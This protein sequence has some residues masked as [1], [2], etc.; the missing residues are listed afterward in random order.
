MANWELVFYETSS[1]RIPVREFIDS[2][3]EYEA[4]RVSQALGVLAELGVELTMPRVRRLGGSPIWELRV[5]GRNQHRV[6]YVAVA[7]Q[8]MLLLH[9]FQKKSQATPRR[10]IETAE[11]RYREYLERQGH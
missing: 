11:Q 9:T 7:D 8:R 6:L 10:E 4:G 1:G 2:L 3:P 5:R